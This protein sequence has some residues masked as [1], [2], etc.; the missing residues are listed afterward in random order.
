MTL[1]PIMQSQ[2]NEAKENFLSLVTHEL[3]TPLSG[4]VCS[5]NLL[6]KA[7]SL[8]DKQKEYLNHLTECTD[9][10]MNILNDILDLNEMKSGKLFLRCSPFSLK[11]CVSSS[12]SVISAKAENKKLKVDVKINDDLPLFFMGDETRLR[13]IIINLLTNSVKFTDRGTITVCIDGKIYKDFDHDYN[14]RMWKLWFS[15]RDTGIGISLEDQKTIFTMFEQCATNKKY[16]S[17]SGVGIGLSIVKNLITLMKGNIKVESDGIPGKGS[18]FVFDIVLPEQPNLEEIVENNCDLIKNTKILVVDDRCENRMLIN[19]ILFK[20]KMHPVCFSSAGEAL[21]HM[22]HKN[23]EFST[24]IVDI[25]MPFMSGE[26]LAQR[27]KTDYPYINII[28]LSSVGEI[29]D[30]ACLFDFFLTKPIEECRL[31][32]V[33]I[34]SLKLKSIERGTLTELPKIRKRRK[35]EGCKILIAEDDNHNSYMLKETLLCLGFSSKKITIVEDGEKCINEAKNKKY[36]VCLMDIR[37]PKMN[38]I[39][40]AK[41]IKHFKHAPLIIALS[42]GT[43]DVCKHEC[44]RVGMVDYITKPVSEEVLK[45]LFRKLGYTFKN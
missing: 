8:N 44:E 3:R 19:E 28:G 39:D 36:D 21:Q 23:E 30:K 13:Q 7:G 15:V 38:G 1:S 31:L 9:Q 37:M 24:A 10:L 18:C 2:I 20:W 34:D 6:L 29:E 40:A 35:I 42:A 4:I 25:N 16:S 33:I 5:A 26:E 43:T 22:K 11:K 27:I 14:S 45:K 41:H 32:P 17:C 12:L